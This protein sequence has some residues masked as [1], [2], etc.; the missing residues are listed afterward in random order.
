MPAR[1]AELAC[2]PQTVLSPTNQSD[3]A[4]S[5]Y[6]RLAADWA[7]R[8][9]VLGAALRRRRQRVTNLA[10]QFR[11]DCLE[12][13]CLLHAA[14]DGSSISVNLYCDEIKETTIRDPISGDEKWAYIGVLVVPVSL[15]GTLLSGLRNRRC[16][17]PDGNKTWGAC[18]SECPFHAANNRPVHYSDAN[19]GDI[20]RVAERWLDFLLSDD[21][22][23][24]FYIL[25]MNLSNL[26]FS[27]FGRVRGSER[28]ERIYNRFF[29]T[30]L[31][32]SVKG[33]FYSY[34][35]III[36]SVVHHQSDLQSSEYFPW[37]VIYRVGRDDQKIEFASHEIEFISSDHR[38]SHDERSHFIQYIDL[39]L[40]SCRNALHWESKNENKT[41]LALKV[42]P[43]LSRLMKN[44]R[45]PNSHFNYVGRLA[46]EFFP[47]Y[48]YSSLSKWERDVAAHSSFYTNREVRVLRKYNPTL[49]D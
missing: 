1:Y 24:R 32:K 48:A 37:H 30:A 36:E 8:T 16:S 3:A 19:S 29:R 46:V 33:C 28:W 26:D 45:N 39:I 6:L 4:R 13:W 27:K 17:H 22:L 15:Q 34:E 25:G 47:E 18:E 5:G 21:K 9:G 44:P 20:F 49:F 11:N 2:I 43:L 7:R 10:V 14:K 23:T 40:G 12:G 35:R 38:E 41:A 31:L 42:E